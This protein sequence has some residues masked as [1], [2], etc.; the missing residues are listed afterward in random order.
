MVI[1]DHINFPGMAGQNP[2]RG[3]NP[4]AFGTRFANHIYTPHLRDLALRFW[5]TASTCPCSAA[6]IHR[7]GWPP[8]E[9]RAEIRMLC[10]LGSDAVGMSTVPETLVAH[11]AAWPYFRHQHHHQHLHDTW[12]RPTR[13]QPRGSQRGRQAH[14]A[15]AER[16]CWDVLREIGLGNVFAESEEADLAGP[17]AR[18]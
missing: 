18:H 7:V 8:T 13:F 17:S 5:A 14:R 12:T 10:I 2:L 6:F 16:C 15:P 4:E 9:D 3:P 1:E 11:H